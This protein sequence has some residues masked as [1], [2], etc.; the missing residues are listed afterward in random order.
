[1]FFWNSLVFSVIQQML[2]IYS[3]VPLP[4][5]NPACTSGSSQV[6]YCW[7]ISWRILSMT[8]LACEM[9]T[10]V[11]KF[12][13]SL[14]LLF[15]FPQLFVKPPQI[16]HMPSFIGMILVTASCTMLQTSVRS[17]SG[18]VST[19]SNPPLSVAHQALCLPDL[20]PWICL[21]LPLYNHKGFDLGHTWM[22]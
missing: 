14:A 16:N 11:Q 22:A 13:H 12:E 4:F 8:L 19:R 20:I 17:L 2:A 5:L 1:M 3:L 9:S 10:I 15:F 18:T 6:T 7:G 21:S